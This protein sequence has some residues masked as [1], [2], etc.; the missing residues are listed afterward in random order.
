MQEL[1]NKIAAELA[2]ET[3]RGNVADYIPQLAHVDPSQFAI[4]LATVDGQRFLRA[5]PPHRSQSRAFPKFLR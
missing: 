4:S 5:A 3:E 2:L 1:L